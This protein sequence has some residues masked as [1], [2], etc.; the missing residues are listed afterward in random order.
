MPVKI[1]PITEEA[2]ARAV[3]W[4]YGNPSD[5]AGAFF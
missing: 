3:G 5:V 2:A 4:E 1:H